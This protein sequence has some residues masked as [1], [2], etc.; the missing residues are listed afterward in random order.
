MQ[1]KHTLPIEITWPPVLATFE[2]P[3]REH[4]Q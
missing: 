3:V 2:Q 4:E 1:I